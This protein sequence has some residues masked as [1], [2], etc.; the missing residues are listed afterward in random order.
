MSDISQMVCIFFLEKHKKTGFPIKS[1][2]KETE[3]HLIVDSLFFM[4]LR[5][6]DWILSA[7]DLKEKVSLGD[8]CRRHRWSRCIPANIERVLI[9]T[10]TVHRRLVQAILLT[11]FVRFCG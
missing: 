7:F 11:Y 1:K 5:V 10:D 8:I 4:F 6:P 2:M 3:T 9:P